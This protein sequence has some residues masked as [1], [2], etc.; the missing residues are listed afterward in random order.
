MLYDWMPTMS[1]FR[2]LPLVERF[3]ELIGQNRVLAPLFAPV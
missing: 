2:L 1:D 3:A